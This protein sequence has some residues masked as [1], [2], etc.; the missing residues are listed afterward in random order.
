MDDLKEIINTTEP[1]LQ[2]IPEILGH[3]SR[4]VDGAD[5]DEVYPHIWLGDWLV[6][7]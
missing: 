2:P 6:V 5:M 1:R 7:E 3:V 4:F